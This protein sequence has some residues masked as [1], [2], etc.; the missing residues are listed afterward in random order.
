MADKRLRWQLFPFFLGIIVVATGVIS[1]VAVVYLRGVALKQ[2]EGDLHYRTQLFAQLIEDAWWDTDSVATVDL[3]KLLPDQSMRVTLIREDGSVL[4][5][6]RYD[7]RSMENH[8]TRR[9]IRQA[10]ERGIGTSRRFSS[11]I[12]ERMLYEA[13]VVVRPNGNRVVVRGSVSL[14]HVDASSRELRLRLIAIAT[15]IA[16]LAALLALHQ[17]RRLSR[18]LEELE[19]RAESF[20]K[21][22]MP[23]EALH[24]PTREVNSLARTLNSMAKQ[25]R[26]R[27]DRVGTQRNLYQAVLDSMAEGVIAIDQHRKIVSLN[28]AASEILALGRDD[29]IGMQVDDVLRNPDLLGCLDSALADGAVGEYEFLTF[30][31][32][33]RRIQA[34]TSQLQGSD[35][36]LRGV[37]AVIA[38]KTRLHQLEN[39][40]KDFVANV[41]HELKTPITTIKGYVETLLDGALE[42]PE[43]A[44]RFL[45]IIHKHALRLGS[46]IQDLLSLSRLDRIDQSAVAEPVDLVKVTRSA[47][48][49][50]QSRADQRGCQLLLELPKSCLVKAEASLLEHAIINLVD[51]AITYGREQGRV[52][53]SIVPSDETVDLEVRDE[54]E[55]IASEHLP[56]LFERFYRVDKARSARTGGTGLGLAIVKH[57]AQ[58]HGG[59]VDVESTLGKGSL[60]RLTIPLG[61]KC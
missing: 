22:E 47:T 17:G 26:E 3:L 52:W 4:G 55:G 48:H 2:T 12:G 8:G 25:L 59:R 38:D 33:E 53:V 10:L 49:Y 24:Y 20:S 36:E 37:V 56:R 31:P 42:S 1:I 7:A 32:D 11:T 51:N 35:K 16:G 58:V 60:F 21:G 50:C 34:I 46:I 40:R 29:V 6:S 23:P 39:V 15:V 30:N 28:E 18:P 19:A 57:I 41:S 14:A 5:D 61:A 45:R 44:E 54:G 9:E 27:L 43:D 13:I